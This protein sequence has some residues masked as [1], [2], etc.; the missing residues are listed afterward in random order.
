MNRKGQ[1][2]GFPMII[3]IAFGII[4]LLVIL[5]MVA[6]WAGWLD[7]SSIFKGIIGR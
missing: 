3:V 6:N 4:A 1:A 2:P 5:L 7:F